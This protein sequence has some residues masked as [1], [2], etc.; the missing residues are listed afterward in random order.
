MAA[1]VTVQTPETGCV[2]TVRVALVIPPA[3]VREVD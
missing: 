1:T 3:G 2:F